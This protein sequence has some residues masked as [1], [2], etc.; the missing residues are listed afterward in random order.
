MANERG[1][2]LNEDPI[3]GSF[4]AGIYMVAAF[5]ILGAV[6]VAFI[7]M[8]GAQ[9]QSATASAAPESA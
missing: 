4:N 6:I 9:R 7:P 8:K 2:D 1:K 3:T 5:L